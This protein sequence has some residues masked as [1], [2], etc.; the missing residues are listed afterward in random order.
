MNISIPPMLGTEIF[1]PSLKKSSNSPWNL[2]PVEV[3]P[4]SHM[5]CIVPPDAL[6]ICASFDDMVRFPHSSDME[7]VHPLTLDRSYGTT[8]FMQ[9]LVFML[10]CR[11]GRVSFLFMMNGFWFISLSCLFRI[12]EAYRFLSHTTGLC[13]CRT[14][15][16]VRLLCSVL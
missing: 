3:S 9:F 8:A 1:L 13:C 12:P 4:S 7:N 10:I 11:F 2:P 15:C 5:Y 14:R 6:T 16:R